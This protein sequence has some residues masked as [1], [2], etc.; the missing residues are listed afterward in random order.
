MFA[1]VPSLG[2][3][4]LPLIGVRQQSLAGIKIIARTSTVKFSSAVAV[5]VTRS[6]FAGYRSTDDDHIDYTSE[7][8]TNCSGPKL[9]LE[10]HRTWYINLKL[11]DVS[12]MNALRAEFVDIKAP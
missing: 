7:L 4:V 1:D 2:A 11:C 6:R 5:N 12:D 10:V 3:S 9:S 8:V